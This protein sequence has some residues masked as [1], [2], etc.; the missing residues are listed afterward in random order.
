MPYLDPAFR[1]EGRFDCLV[2]MLA[3]SQ[4]DR[5]EILRAHLETV[6]RVPH[7]LEAEDIALICRRLDGW[8]GNMIE[9]LVKRACRVALRER[10]DEV[11][12]FA[13]H[14]AME[15]YIVDRAALRA[16][17]E[18]YSAMALELANSRRFLKL[19]ANCC[20]RQEA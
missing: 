14:E 20:H 19:S 8:K 18:R 10:R 2:P 17:S 7:M 15:D 12:V 13:F 6:R 9:E 11:D 3:P 1:R 16:E 4:E 5:E